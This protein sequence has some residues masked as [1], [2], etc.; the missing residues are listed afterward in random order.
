MPAEARTSSLV[1]D[2]RLVFELASLKRE[3]GRNLGADD[4]REL[5]TINETHQGRRRSVVE[6]F[7]LSY[8]RRVAAASQRLIDEAGDKPLDLNPRSLGR[9]RFDR[10]AI[11]RQAH[12]E[13]NLARRHALGRIDRDE[14]RAIEGLLARADQKNQA[15][16]VAKRDFAGAADRR[17]G[18]NRRLR[19]H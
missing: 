2:V 13:V 11:D 1:E 3:A 4:W 10:G 18:A 8:G 7:E 14:A 9:N 19:R 12:L 15:R 6:D 5:R 17:G 16:E